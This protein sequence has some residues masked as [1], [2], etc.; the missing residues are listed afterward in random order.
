MIV[1]PAID[2]LDGHAVRLHKGEYG[3]ST[4]YEDRPIDAAARW[5][6]QGASSLHI[7]D[8]DGA[9]EG[10]PVNLSEIAAVASGIG[11]PVQVGGGVRDLE[12]VRVLLDVGVE[13]IVIGTAAIRD[14]DFL[15]GALDL[16]G[17]ERLVVALDA[18]SGEV[19]VEGWTEGS[20]VSAADAIVDL[21]ER[22]ARRFLFTAIETDG[23]L[24]GPDV[25]ALSEVA[26]STPHPVIASGG[27]GSLEDL[28]SLASRA[29]DNVEAVIVGKALYEGR[30]TVAEAAQAVR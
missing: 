24:E 19:A 16:A 20:G 2:I 26:G 13:R 5:V 11:I 28:A 7:V 27:I 9:R 8:L 15:R 1:L 23:T 21:G 22:G 12:T 10:R 29:P 3:A 17:V 6:E 25:E 30:F 4:V 18:R 14:P